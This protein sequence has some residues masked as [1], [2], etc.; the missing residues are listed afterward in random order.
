MRRGESL[1]EALM[2]LVILGLILPLAFQSLWSGQEGLERLRRRD[3]CLYAAQ[4]WFNRLPRNG[5]L[6]DMPRTTPGGDVLFTWESR[7][8]N[9][10]R[11][12]VILTVS[13]LRGEPLTLARVF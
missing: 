1:M 4:W 11:R 2:A 3:T 9:A 5:S 12:E 8:G 6:S 10:G 13:P 7:S